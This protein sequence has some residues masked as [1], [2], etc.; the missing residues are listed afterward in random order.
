MTIEKHLTHESLLNV[1][2]I[3]RSLKDELQLIIDLK[4]TEKND[5]IKKI[6]NDL[7]TNLSVLIDRFRNEINEIY[8]NSEL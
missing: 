2:W 1:Q 5:N 4:C 6:L 3:E 8:S 7:D